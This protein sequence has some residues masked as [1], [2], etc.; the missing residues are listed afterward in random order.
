MPEQESEAPCIP[1]VFSSEEGPER[2]MVWGQHHLEG[3]VPTHHAR[4]VGGLTLE[5]SNKGRVKERC[6]R[7]RTLEVRSLKATLRLARDS[8]ATA[9]AGPPRQSAGPRQIVP[10]SPSRTCKHGKHASIYSKAS[11]FSGGQND[12]KHSLPVFLESLSLFTKSITFVCS[13]N[14]NYRAQ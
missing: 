6:H 9:A 11:A 5:S 14:Q 13:K 10:R 1:F 3:S 8:G 4:P 2:P 7:G 12:K